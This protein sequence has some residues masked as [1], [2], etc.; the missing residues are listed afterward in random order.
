M[1]ALDYHVIEGATGTSADELEALYNELGAEGWKLTHVVELIQN[2]RRAIFVQAG[3]MVEY[4]VTDYATG[5][6]AAAVE[7][8]LDQLG[9]DGWLLAQIVSLKQN[10]RRA[11]MMRGPGVDGGGGGGAG[12]GIDEAPQDNVTYGRLNAAWTPALA[13]S[14]D[15]LDGGSF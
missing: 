8:T 2:R 10:E 6:D 12:G 4:L 15:I 3:A 9:A 13:L 7:A 11:I 14:N 5:Q 1:A